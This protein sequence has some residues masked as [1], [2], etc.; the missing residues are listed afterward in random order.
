MIVLLHDTDPAQNQ[1]I[2]IPA[3]DASLLIP[4]TKIVNLTNPALIAAAN[5]ALGIVNDD[6]NLANPA[7]YNGWRAF[8][9]TRKAGG[10]RAGKQ[11][12]LPAP[13]E[14]GDADAPPDD[15]GEV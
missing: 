10:A 2:L 7:N 8:V 3:Y 4:G 11:R 1:E 13:T 15:P 9:T 6:D 12:N 14:P 5:A